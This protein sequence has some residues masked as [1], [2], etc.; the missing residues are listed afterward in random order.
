[1]SRAP[2]P[3]HSPRREQ[4][5]TQTRQDILRAAREL[6]VTQGYA[7]VTMSD[8]ARATG[9]AVKTV[10]ASVG[11]KPEVLHELL[12]GDVAASNATETHDEVVRAPDLR[13]AVQAIASSTRANTER[14]K[15]SIDLLYSSMSSDEG[16]RRIGKQVVQEYRHALR[17]AA[18]HLVA[19]GLVAPDL[20]SDGVADRLWFCFGLA[21]WRALVIDCGWSYAESERWLGHHCYIMLSDSSCSSSGGDL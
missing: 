12:L 14:F 8:I 19:A 6:F 7:M 11:T 1:V 5:A 21:A 10:Y 20:D 13:S 18:E 9:V 17:V 2:R 16:A 4:H 15:S 3:Y